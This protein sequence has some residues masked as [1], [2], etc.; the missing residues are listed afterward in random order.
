[1]SERKT[2]F[3]IRI[4]EDSAKELDKVVEK[5]EYLDVSKSEVV[6]AILMAYFEPDT[7]H[8]EKAREL[9]IRKRKGK[10]RKNRFKLMHLVHEEIKI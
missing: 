5:S 6:E 4:G 10:Y 2:S 3:G 9:I 1:M 7:N 8:V